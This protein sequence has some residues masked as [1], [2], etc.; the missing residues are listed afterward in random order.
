MCVRVTMTPKMT[1]FHISGEHKGRLTYIF[2]NNEKIVLCSLSLKPIEHVFIGF[3]R[4]YGMR[5]RIKC[6]SCRVLCFLFL[7]NNNKKRKT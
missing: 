7:D 5:T 3:F 4:L 6:V 1:N 2:D